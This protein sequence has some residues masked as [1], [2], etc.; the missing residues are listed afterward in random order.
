VR[1]RSSLIEGELG[2]CGAGVK[3]AVRLRPIQRWFAVVSFNSRSARASG[4]RFGLDPSRCGN[5][6]GAMLLAK[7]RLGLVLGTF[8]MLAFSGTLPAT[9]IAVP[10]L[11]PAILTFGRIEVAALLG[12]VTLLLTRQRI[13]PRCHWAGLLWMGTGL[14][15]G[16]PLF[17]ALALRDVP[18]AHGSVIIGL[19]PG[20]TAALA[21]LRAGE[22]PPLRFWIACAT[23]LLAIAAFAYREGGGTI[24]AA[25]GW[26]VLA[27]LSVAVA[28]VEGRR[29][30]RALGG[31]I[32]LC[33]AM[34]ALAPIAAIPCSVALWRHD[35]SAA[36]NTLPAW[37]AFAYAAVISMFFGSVAWYRGLALGGIARVGQ[38]N[39][40]QPLLAL[41]WAALLIGEKIGAAAA[42]CAAV[43]VA[44]MLVCIRSRIS[45][46]AA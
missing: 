8:G 13:P 45:R 25:D 17:I 43:V 22:R 4:Q 33:W 2:L 12:L 20:A 6:H 26:L 34:V 5:K 28:Y 27:I 41:L 35:W 1:I 39:L 21:V 11:G 10:T 40:L 24:N 38:L 16:Y 19:A 14:A 7:E 31:T 29:V 18:A 42:I 46:P 44:A 32:A 36:A 37:T 9:R 30:S 3:P 15:I 23:G